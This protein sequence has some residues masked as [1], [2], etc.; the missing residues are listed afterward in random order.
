MLGE[1]LGGPN[2]IKPSALTPYGY[3]VDFECILDK[4]KKPL[5]HGSQDEDELPSVLWGPDVHESRSALPLGA[6]RVA[7]EFLDSRAFC[8]NT[9]HLKGR[10]SMKKRHLEILGYRVIQIPHLEWNSMELSTKDAWMEYLRERM[11]AEV[12]S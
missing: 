5:P 10:S 12:Q 3:I 4:E 7:L 6:Q 1:I 8:K 2:Y 9:T 11:F